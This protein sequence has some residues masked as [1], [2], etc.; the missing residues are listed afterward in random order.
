MTEYSIA[1]QLKWKWGRVAAGICL[2]L[3]LLLIPSIAR[4]DAPEELFK[5]PRSGDLT[6][7][8]GAG[9]LKNPRGMGTDP[10]TGHVF[11]AEATNSRISEFT[12][13]GAFVKAWGW[14]VADGSPELQV[15]GPAE[16]GVEPDPA[17]CRR[18]IKGDGPGQLLEPYGLAVDAS[19]NVYVADVSYEGELRTRVQKFSPAGEFLWMVGGEVNQTTHANLCTKADL[20]AGQECGGG[21]LGSGPGQFATSSLGNYVAIGPDGTLFVGDVGRIQEFD[22]AGTYKGEI[23]L[24]G[25]LAGKTVDQLAIDPDGNFYL[26]L[27][28]EDQVRKLGPSGDLLAPSFP[29]TGVRAIATD[30]DGNLYAVENPVGFGTVEV[31]PRVV[32][33][34][35][36]DAV[37]VGPED[38]FA[39]P[40]ARQFGSDVNGL[41][42][43]VLGESSK[44]PGDLY[45]SVFDGPQAYVSV[46]GPEP[47]FEPAPEVPPEIAAQYATAVGGASASVGAEINPHF[48]PGTTYQVEYGTGK[49]S[50]GGCTAT[51][52]PAPLGAHRDAPAA[53]APVQL[54]GLAPGTTYHYR[55]L[56]VSGPFSVRGVGAEEAEATFTTAVPPPAGLPDKRAYEMVSPP[57]KNNADVPNGSP[58]LSVAPLQASASGDAITYPAFI[59]FGED[60]QSAPSASQ[61]LA[62]RGVTGWSTQNLTP[63]DEESYLTDPLRGFS[64]DL[65]KAAVITL[66]PPLLPEAPPGFHSLYL[67]DTATEELQLASTAAPQLTYDSTG[68]CVEFDGASAD[69]SR[70]IFAA[71]GALRQGDPVP[72]TSEDFNLYEWSAAAGLRLVSMLPGEEPSKPKTVIGYG[73]ED[74]CAGTP[75]EPVRG[76]ISA[77]GQTIFWSAAS[78]SFATNLYARIGST[79]T[80]QIDK[81]EGGPGP[82]GGG[83]FWAASE[84]GSRVFFTDRNKLTAAGGAVEG[85]FGDLYRYDFR[86]PEGERLFDLSASP[87]ALGILGV[88]GAGADGSAV[89]FASEA[90][91]AGNEGPA[92]GSA[93]AGEPNVYRWQEGEGTRFLAALSDAPEAQGGTD[94]FNWV[95]E[96]LHQTARVS[97]DG[98]HLAFVSTMSLTGYDNIDQQTGKPAAQVYLYD[99]AADELRCASCNLTGARPL[100]RSWVPTWN[101]PYEQPRY[102]SDD[103][104]RLFFESEDALEEHDTDGGLDVY[105][106][107]LAGTGG[108]TTQEPTY[109]PDSGGCL[110]LL[111]GGAAETPAHFLDASTTGDDAFVSTRERLVARDEDDNLDIYD[112]RVGGFEPPLPPPPVPCE[113]EGCR[114]PGAE[115]GPVS[116]FGTSAFQG[117]G[118]P[119]QV[120]QC[121][122]PR[123]KVTRKG[124]VRCVKPR[125]KRHHKHKRGHRHPQGR[126][127]R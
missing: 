26:V 37:I 51:T 74:A 84:D 54:S 24:E 103:G 16:P 30:L 17:L 108:C 98:E 99:A 82:S 6:A 13:W 96:P 114:G 102:L 50:E 48:F 123:R 47:Q 32:V 53:T 22:L 39:M 61:Y 118:N 109:S 58:G 55:F 73:A 83:T 70:V 15:C 42:T 60:P 115:P 44:A 110:Y 5:I 80:I 92:G 100:G 14:G 76:A 120:A 78:K 113:G 3:L 116:A 68:Y 18:G 112:V 29:V 90:V 10:D 122:K 33:F 45:V 1:G 69:F 127:A 9:Q 111:S 35:P 93:R 12:S 21:I 119:K 86:A 65:A 23:E 125:H 121:K 106:F 56:A 117:P 40:S 94:Q 19:G 95:D 2:A 91:L 4:A 57:Q 28:G 72:A 27:A 49:C 52:A 36:G 75:D 63:P 25:K 59:A 71:S 79:E 8:A 77:D 66:E 88:L 43:N 104:A 101:T 107:E 38:R 97:P 31:E 11:V 89:Y 20:E 64:R 81:K 62:R 7:G 124:K 41:A 105:E 87:E 46:F 67:M 126:T 85:G 34:D